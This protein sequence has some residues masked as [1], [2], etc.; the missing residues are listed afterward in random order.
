M[1]YIKK[2]KQSELIPWLGIAGFTFIFLFIVFNMTLWDMVL[3]FLFPGLEEVIYPRAKLS[4]LLGEHLILVSVSSLSAIAVGI[5]LGV[6]VTRKLGSSFEGIV[7]DLGSLS[8]TIP[9]VAVLALAVPLVGFGFKPTVFALFLY[10]ILPI[11]RNTISG[12]EDVSPVIK[13]AAIGMG[14]TRSQ[15]LF[16]VELPLAAPV[17]FAGIRISV[18]VNVGTA[19]I[20][21]VVGAGGL[22]NPIISGLIWDNQAFILEGAVTAAFLAVLIDQFIG[23]LEKHL[24][25]E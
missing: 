13:E 21:A 15:L 23:R 17:L 7:S 22:G 6:F 18:V 16:R 5:P 14:M 2:I 3:S 24:T 12:L 8:Q 11:L 1:N 10:S 19:T 4:Q 9:P 20:G 25:P